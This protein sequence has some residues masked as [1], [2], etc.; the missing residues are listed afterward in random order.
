MPQVRG[1][2]GGQVPKAVEGSKGEVKRKSSDQS[3][4]S[5]EFLWRE[6][7]C[8]GRTKSHFWNYIT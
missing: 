3:K 1:H 8:E 5:V 7:L 4:D 6:H 2:V